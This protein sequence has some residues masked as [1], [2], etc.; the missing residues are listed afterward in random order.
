[1]FFLFQ[2][3][4]GSHLTI[5]TNCVSDLNCRHS[6]VHLTEQLLFAKRTF[7]IPF[8]LSCTDVG[9]KPQTPWVK[10]QRAQNSLLPEL[11][12]MPRSAV[13]DVHVQKKTCFIHTQDQWV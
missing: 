8:G 9:F 2:G 13:R 11:A 3:F 4:R 10:A 12:E 6:P 5:L 1:M 7:A